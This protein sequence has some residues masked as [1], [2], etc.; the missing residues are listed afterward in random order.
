MRLSRFVVVFGVLHAVSPVQ[1]ETI[2]YNVDL[3]GTTEGG[4]HPHTP[5]S[6][7]GT[8]TFDTVLDTIT[9]STLTFSSDV[10]YSRILMWEIRKPGLW[11][12]VATPDGRLFFHQKVPS[13]LYHAGG[14]EWHFDP[15]PS[16]NYYL[17]LL[18]IS[19]TGDGIPVLS[20]AYGQF[21]IDLVDV[22]T[23]FFS[24]PD[25]LIGTVPEPSTFLM[26]MTALMGGVWGLR[27]RIIVANK[28]E[29]L[30]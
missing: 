22:A 25:V 27:G 1:A 12:Y 5:V 8:V 7:T 6:V 9:N 30:A 15:I 16:T 17:A 18:S 10:T 23:I 26:A 14:L 3:H 28:A 29:T 21:S 24:T 13:E 2:V 20:L 11:D 4:Y 19:T